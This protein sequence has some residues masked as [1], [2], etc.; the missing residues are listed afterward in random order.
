[1]K[2]TRFTRKELS[3][4]GYSDPQLVKV[5]NKIIVKL[6]GNVKKDEIFRVL[7]EIESKPKKYA[8]HPL[9]S[10]IL[11][12]IHSSDKNETQCNDDEL[13][14]DCKIFGENIIDPAA[15]QQMND[16][17]KLPVVEKG[18]LMPDAHVGYGLPIGGVV[19][20]RNK[21]MP[22][23]VGMDIG[24][25]MCMSIYEMPVDYLNKKNDLEEILI[26]NTRFGRSVFQERL[27]HPVLDRKEFTE[28]SFL[29]QLHVKA[30]EQL[31]TSGHGNH[32]VDIGLL[33]IEQQDD[34]LNIRPGVYFAVLSHSGSRNMG[35]E[36]ARHYTQIA[37]QR[38]NLSGEAAKMAW[39]NLDSDEGIEYWLAMN[40]AGDYSKAN[41]HIIH[42]K[43]SRAFGTNPFLMI[44]NHH[45]FAWKEV[46]E[47]G[48]EY[49]VHRKGATPA[50]IDS[51]GIIPGSMTT[52]AYIIKGKGNKDSISSASHGAGRM[53]SRRQ[54]KK[55]FTHSQMIAQLDHY[56]VHLIGG[57][58][59]EIPGAYKNI[60]GVME[61]QKD[62]VEVL[63]TF[64]PKI[65][66]ME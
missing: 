15:I 48:N 44:E 37:K 8:H 54:A 14:S 62:L 3:G 19:A 56:G 6:P 13:K 18:A 28:I 2:K 36:I 22:Y 65:V 41:H 32:F 27:D 64:Q 17:M 26:E 35:A 46:L 4:F 57:K 16:A 1:M 29:K 25:R 58:L 7:K 12:Y 24:C 61:Y 40:L 9:F 5:I 47:D 53:F 63:G 43:L 59:D 10:K 21:V 50:H 39:L 33:E 52:P 38:Q 55:Q 51:T 42:N 45:N 31:G 20:T 30:K 49:I 34:L 66:R 23:A 11:P 60:N